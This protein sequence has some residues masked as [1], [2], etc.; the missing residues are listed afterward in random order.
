M[1]SSNSKDLVFILK[2]L[3]IIINRNTNAVTI[4]SII[5]IPPPFAFVFH[6]SQ[7]GKRT[8]TTFKISV[9]YG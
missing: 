8:T 6:N 2:A 3:I 4:I 7:G 1:L 5:P 9:L